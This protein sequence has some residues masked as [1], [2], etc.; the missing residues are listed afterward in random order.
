MQF[1]RINRFS[2]LPLRAATYSN[3][4]HSLIPPFVYIP[5]GESYVHSQFPFPAFNVA[6]SGICGG[7]GLM[8][9]LSFKKPK[10]GQTWA[11]KGKVPSESKEVIAAEEENEE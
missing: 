7:V 1:Y 10:P 3:T 8:F 2:H 9:L 6:D 5:H 4:S 11:K